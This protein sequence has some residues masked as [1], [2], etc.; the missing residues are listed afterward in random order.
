MFTRIT[1]TLALIALS[2]SLALAQRGGGPGSGGDHIE[3]RIER[4]TQLLELTTAQQQQATTIF[5]NAETA[6]AALRETSVAARTALNTAVKANNTAGIDQA[7]NTLGTISGQTTA[8]D[9]KAE[10]AF[11]QILTVD[12]RAKYDE[13]RMG[14]GPRGP[15][16]QG[17]RRAPR[18]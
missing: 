14:G 6:R 11:Y 13:S 10:A 3:N 16:A 18:Q 2:A 9:A 7:A 15:G 1:R 5:T 12:Q 4:L 8:I 17:L